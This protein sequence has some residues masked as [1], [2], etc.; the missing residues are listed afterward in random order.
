MYLFF[1]GLSYR[2]LSVPGR[3]LVD[4]QTSSVS[5]LI[6]LPCCHMKLVYT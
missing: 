4:L 6:L 1:Q 3:R 2:A 5:E